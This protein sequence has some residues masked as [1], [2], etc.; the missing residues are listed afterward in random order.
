MQLTDGDERFELR[1]RL[2]SGSFGIVYEA[3]DRYRNRTVALKVLEHAVPDAVARF[4]RE[5]RYLVE[6]RHRNLASLYELLM[7]Q[8]R[9]ALSMELIRGS[10]LLEHLAIAELQNSLFASREGTGPPGDQTLRFKPRKTNR[11]ISPL[12]FDRVRDTFSQLATGTAMLHAHGIVHR[13]I[14]PSNIM[15]TSG[16]RVVL[17]DFGLVVE[18]AHDDSLDRKTVVG[19]PGY[20]APEQISGATPNAS[21]DWYSVGVLLYQAVTGRMPFT[22]STSLEVL[23]MQLHADAPL[24]REVVDEVPEDLASL[25]DACIRRDPQSR[26][27]DPEILHRLGIRDFDA[28]RLERKRARRPHLVGRDRELKALTSWIASTQPG[29]PYVAALHGAPGSGK[30]ALLDVALNRLRA[31]ENA[32]IIGGQ[33][34]AWESVPLNAIDVIV[35]SLA[36]ELRRQRPPAVDEIMSRSVAVTQLFPVLLNTSAASL[37]DETIALPATGQKLIARAASELRS[38]LFAVAG[39]RP[40]LLFLD[41]AQWGDFQS[42]QVLLKLLKPQRG[43]RL[44]LILCYQSEDWRTSLLL[45]ALLGSGTAMREFRLKDLSRV[46]TAQMVQRATG[47]RGKRLAD[48]IFRVTGGNPAMI[49][50]AIESLRRHSAN[51]PSLMAWAVACRLQSLSLPAHRLFTWLLTPP[52]AVG[53]ETV[54]EA[55]E[56]F[57]I[58]EPLRMLRRERLIRLRKTGDL[59]AIE[60]YHPRIRQAFDVA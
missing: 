30:S 11:K 40:L 29:V 15:I 24:V 28:A 3:F 55:L 45:Q 33:C 34:Q 51:D 47:Q 44:S 25:A 6:V 52:G 20:M 56:L 10:E 1:R 14:K 43:R 19:T 18:R 7:V 26:P 9:W 42:A 8:D 59:R 38:I 31:G 4:K 58:D 49:E 50:M 21:A 35:D 36:R 39:D 22:A 37:A 17:L 60:I 54:A 12:Y 53:E 48:R 13:D 41:D 57:E 5:F 27:D 46:M 2:G 16:G 23:Q 32:C